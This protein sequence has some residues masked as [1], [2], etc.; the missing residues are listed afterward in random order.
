MNRGDEHGHTLKHMHSHQF[1]LSRNKIMNMLKI[2]QLPSGLE[3]QHV[4]DGA[5]AIH[6]HN[7]NRRPNPSVR[8]HRVLFHAL[9]F[10]QATYC[11]IFTFQYRIAHGHGL[12]NWNSKIQVC[13][14]L[15]LRTYRVYTDLNS[16]LTFAF[17]GLTCTYSMMSVLTKRSL[18]VL[19]KGRQ[20]TKVLVQ[21]TSNQQFLVR[22]NDIHIRSA[23]VK[24]V[25]NISQ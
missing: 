18:T 12:G 15:F 13:W 20:H 8:G 3:I 19:L 22:I 7:L 16:P 25:K 23:T 17:R 1:V 5:V 21:K 14:R 4:S 9:H 6:I 2:V 10:A 11:S 24:F